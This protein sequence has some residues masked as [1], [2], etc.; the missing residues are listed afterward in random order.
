MICTI[1]RLIILIYQSYTM[2]LKLIS[3]VKTQLN[4]LD[5]NHA[6]DYNIYKLLVNEFKNLFFLVKILG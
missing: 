1:L 2:Y 5:D 4:Y 6:T 3:P